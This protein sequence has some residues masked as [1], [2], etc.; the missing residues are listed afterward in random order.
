M[1]VVGPS[2][3]AEDIRPLQGRRMGRKHVTIP[4]GSIVE[5][6]PAGE[7]NYQQY[8]YRLVRAAGEPEPA[9]EPDKRPPGWPPQQHDVWTDNDGIVYCLNWGGTFRH[10]GARELMYSS[11]GRNGFYPD[12]SKLPA[13]LTL[14]LRRR[15]NAWESQDRKTW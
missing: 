13:G 15:V 10:S 7:G 12:D 2:C 11:T 8:R 14:R 9:P 1:H 5:L 3:A 6:V 4:D